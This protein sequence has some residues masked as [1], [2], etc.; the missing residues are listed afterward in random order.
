MERGELTLSQVHAAALVLR[1][2]ALSLAPRD[3]CST[4]Q[5]PNQNSKCEI[6]TWKC[7]LYLQHNMHQCPERGICL[8]P[9]FSLFVLQTMWR[10]LGK[11]Q[12]S[13]ISH[14]SSY[15]CAGLTQHPPLAVWSTHT[16]CKHASPITS[17]SCLHKAGEQG[18]LVPRP[19]PVFVLWFAFSI[20]HGSGRVYILNTNWRTKMVE[21]WERS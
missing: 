8:Y 17:D 18:S 10:Y 7:Y 13:A 15:D 19:S 9:C 14:I 21:A 6:E 5:N 2:Q 20:I 11:K 1:S 4:S 16:F 3:Y 12:H